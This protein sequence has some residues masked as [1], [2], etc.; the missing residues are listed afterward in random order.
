MTRV[1][2]SAIRR[3]TCGVVAA[4]L[5]CACDELPAGADEVTLT[6]TEF[7]T[8]EPPDGPGFRVQMRARV[9]QGLEEL[10][11]AVQGG[12]AEAGVCLASACVDYALA[13]GF[14]ASTCPG[15]PVVNDGGTSL[16]IARAW[17]A[18]NVV[19]IDFCVVGLT[20]QRQFE[21]VVRFGTHTSNT[22]FT[23]CLPPGPTCESA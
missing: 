23:T 1:E 16:S 19:A 18:S 6:L 11:M 2:G 22:V 12:T 10:Q 4:F 15:M 14:A 8:D 3:A 5:L 21:S 9:T 20:G 7:Q 13:N 17:L